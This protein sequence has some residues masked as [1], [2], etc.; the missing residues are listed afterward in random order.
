[1]RIRDSEVLEPIYRLIVR[2]EADEQGQLYNV[3]YARY[4]TFR[5]ACYA[6]RLF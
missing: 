3:S 6:R 5:E 1:M 2:R 4:K